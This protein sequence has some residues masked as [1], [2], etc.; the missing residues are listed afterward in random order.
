M[1]KFDKSHNRT[2]MPAFI[3]ITLIICILPL[4]YLVF[5]S[6]SNGQNQPII[7]MIIGAYLSYLGGCINYWVGT[8]FSSGSKDQ[9]LYNSKPINT[10]KT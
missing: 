1:A 4:S 10:D 5:T 2:Y 7:N 6:D 8:S 9:M 3:T